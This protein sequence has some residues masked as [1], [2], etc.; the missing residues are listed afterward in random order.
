GMIEELISTLRNDYTII[1]VTHNM[2]QASRVSDYT[3]FY[4]VDG[5]RTGYL[6]E[7]GKTGDLFLNPKNDKTEQYISGKFG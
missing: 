4:M 1:I 6:E 2:S 3:A 7:Y 5:K